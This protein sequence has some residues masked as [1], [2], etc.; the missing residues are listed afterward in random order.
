MK[1]KTRTAPP[2][3]DVQLFHLY[4]NGCRS[5][6]KW[7]SYHRR[8]HGRH[9]LGCLRFGEKWLQLWDA[10]GRLLV[11]PARREGKRRST[12]FVIDHDTV[13]NSLKFEITRAG[14]DPLRKGAGCRVVLLD[15]TIVKEWGGK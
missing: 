4:P 6:G 13:A 1:R 14:I 9:P 15:G 11:R 12:W 8:M 5:F 7:L 2:T 3:N 10:V